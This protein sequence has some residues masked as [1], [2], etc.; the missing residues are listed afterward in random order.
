MFA[1]ISLDVQDDYVVTKSI[2]GKA[3]DT[4]RHAGD[5]LFYKN[6]EEIPSALVFDTEDGQSGWWMNESYW[7]P[8]SRTLRLIKFFGVL[9]SILGI[10]SFGIYGVISEL[11]RLISK[12]RDHSI[13]HY[14]LLGSCLS[15]GLMFLAFA[16]TMENVRNA[17][18]MNLSSILFLSAP[19]LMI[20]CTLASVLSWRNIWQGHI[21]R[22]IYYSWVLLSCIIM[23]VY[24]WQIGFVGLKLWSY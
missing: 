14:L 22:K 4:L 11:V 21:G 18:E 13:S 7:L 16:N 8:S 9:L 17:G 12:K 1:G 15:F 24:L 23:L 2:L 3:R 6:E 20:V 10:I 5:G 19:F